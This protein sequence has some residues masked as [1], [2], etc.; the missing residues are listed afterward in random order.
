MY[1]RHL[2]LP[3][4]VLE[5][6]LQR[7][8]SQLVVLGIVEYKKIGQKNVTL[9]NCE[10]LTEIVEAYLLTGVHSKT[11]PLEVQHFVGN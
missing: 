2:H 9:M 1:L 11:L 3:E 10:Y 6:V 7:I 5:H 4:D 8:L